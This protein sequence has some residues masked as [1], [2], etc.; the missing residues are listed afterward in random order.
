MSVSPAQFMID[1][2]T[3]PPWCQVHH[4]WGPGHVWH[5]SAPAV[6]DVQSFWSVSNECSGGPGIAGPG[7]VIVV[8]AAPGLPAS[9]TVWLSASDAMELAVALVRHAQQE[10]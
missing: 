5:G 6:R 3:C 2:P 8:L 1:N 10:V 9:A 7:I 4:E